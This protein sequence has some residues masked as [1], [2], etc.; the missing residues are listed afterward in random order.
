M[1]TVLAAL[2][3][4]A[5]LAGCSREPAAERFGGPTM[6]TSYSVVVTRMPA[7]LDRARVQALIDDVLREVDDHLSTYD[8]A[9]EISGFNARPGTDW[10]PVSPLLYSVVER[11]RQVYRES[12]GAFDIT[13]GP[14]VQLWGF[15]ADARAIEA[16]PDPH[17]IEHARG[18]TG[19]DKLEARAEGPALRKTS[20]GLRLDV[21]GIAPGLAVDLIVER[22]RSAGIEDCLVEIGGEVRARGRSPAGRIWR[23]AVEVPLTGER[24]PYTLVELDDLAVSTSGDYRD[25]RLVGGHRVSHT[26]DPRTGA[27]VTHDLASVSVLHPSTALAD[28]YATALMVL[29]PEEGMAMARR[30]GLAALF[31]ERSGTEDGFRE[32]VTP[33][34]TRLR[35]PVT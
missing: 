15:G 26:V 5:T 30:L 9:S 25:F 29:G 22:L 34:F 6:G 28:A 11:A 23:I 13:V 32:R 7:G 10:R 21:D 12:G 20:S 18:V 16:M 4:L 33:E 1:S 31:I 35:R 17:L 8:P 2:T 19:L 24:R 27:P 3:V 14:L